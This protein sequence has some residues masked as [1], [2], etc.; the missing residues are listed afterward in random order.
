M[1]WNRIEIEELKNNIFYYVDNKK[2]AEIVFQRNWNSIEIQAIRLGML[3]LESVH[4][5]TDSELKNLKERYLYYVNHKEEAE[6][7]FQR[8]WRS[9]YEK[10]LQLKI[11]SMQTNKKCPMFLGCYVAER[12]L[13]HIFKDVERMPTGNKGYDFICNKG[14][15]IDVK[16]SCVTLR[17]NCYNFSIRC[18]KIADYFL[19]IGFDNRDNLNPQC[20]WLIKSNET[21]HNKKLNEFKALTIQNTKYGLSQFLKYELNDKLKE[22][23]E[24]CNELKT[25]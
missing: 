5:W 12:V 7:K 11:T 1:K 20:I 16:S 17:N 24:C 23:I 3:T 18:N 22:M 6:N 13:S 2:K 19:C 14:F 10:S 8:K 4:Y 15:K 9:I 25:N 21:I